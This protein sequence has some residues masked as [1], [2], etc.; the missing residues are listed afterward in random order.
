MTAPIEAVA[1]AVSLRP[2]LLDGAGVVNAIGAGLP[3]SPAGFGQILFQ[4]VEGVNAELNAA[5]Q[6]T[7]A[8]ALGEDIPLHQV[9]YALEHSR[10]SFELFSQ[11]RTRLLEGYQELM[12]MPI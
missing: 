6:L 4:G 3:A 1:S 11:I 7:R 5:D 8:F 10:L 12:R 2:A 9:T